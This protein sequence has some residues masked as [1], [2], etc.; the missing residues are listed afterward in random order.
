MGPRY[1]RAE[2]RE[3]A[4]VLGVAVVGVALVLLVAFVPWYGPMMIG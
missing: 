4:F 1:T 2:R 3:F